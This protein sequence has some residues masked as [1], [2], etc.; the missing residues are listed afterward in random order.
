MGA[1]TPEERKRSKYAAMMRDRGTP[2]HI[3]DEEH[4]QLVAHIMKLY[5]RGMSCQ[6][7]L[8]SVPGGTTIHDSAVS[9][10]TRGQVGKCHRDT[11]NT[12]MRARFVQPT[13][14]KTGRRIDGTGHRRRI[15]ALVADGWP[16][17]LLGE[18]TGVSTQAIFQQA[19][20]ERDV[21]ASTV[22]NFVP[23]YEKLS[24]ADP[25]DYGAGKL[26]V[27]RAK[28]NA[29]RRNWAPSL[30]WDD[31]TIDDPDAFPEWTGAC[32]TVT[33][34]NLHRSERVHVNEARDKNGKLRMTVL[35]VACCDARVSAKSDQA[36]RLAE[37]RE[38][39]VSMLAEG[40]SPQF[41]AAEVGLSTRTIDRVRKELSD[42]SA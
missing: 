20:A 22:A 1:K 38:S 29:A 8:D 39:I 23:W 9:K 7:I 25:R 35:C 26:G 21:H 4:A 36:A 16:L 37:R 12:L 14:L 40:K 17:S 24:C 2:L 33:G 27:S 42:G 3:T 15:R 19:T 34:Y 10:I 18:L 11:Y 6:S 13:E 41:I 28:G 30:C 32:G 31:D 5:R